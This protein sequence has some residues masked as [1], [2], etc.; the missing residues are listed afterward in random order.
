MDLKASETETWK[1][2]TLSNLA[3]VF[4]LISA[5]WSLFLHA[6]ARRITLL[7]CF[8]AIG[9]GFLWQATLKTQGRHSAIQKWLFSKSAVVSGVAPNLPLPKERYYVV[10]FK[11]NMTYN[12]TFISSRLGCFLHICAASGAV[13]QCG[14]GVFRTRTWLQWNVDTSCKPPNV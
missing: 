11:G 8:S 10:H 13:Q 1:T 12:K 5:I 14:G 3:H 7:K 9:R 2:P 6:K 4:L